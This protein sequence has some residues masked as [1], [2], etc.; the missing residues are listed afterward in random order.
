ME[1]FFADITLPQ[2][3]Q[4]LVQSLDGPLTSDEVAN[5]VHALQTNKSPGPDGFPVEFYQKFSKDLVPLLL[6]M[7]N[8]SLESGCLPKTLGE[9]SISLLLKKGKDPQSC[10]SY[11]PVSLLPVDFKILAKV[12]ATRL[13]SVLPHII[14]P[15]QT[16]FVKNRHFSTSVGYL[17]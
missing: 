7:Y 9:A 17:I 4:V 15:D 2:D 5:A 6:N 11:R 16:G 10:S 14:S 1:Q 13:E 8:E 12:L 3:D